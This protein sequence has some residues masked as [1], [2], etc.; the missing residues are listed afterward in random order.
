MKT[1]LGWQSEQGHN[2]NKTP[3]CHY[4]QLFVKEKY[5]HETLCKTTN[6]QF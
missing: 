5:H 2:D 6:W 4:N 3:G 1:D